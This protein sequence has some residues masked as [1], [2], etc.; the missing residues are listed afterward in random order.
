M[1]DPV[2]SPKKQF[3][4][5][6]TIVT[7]EYLSAT[8]GYG[9]QAA[10]GYGISSAS[11]LYNGH[12]HN[13][14]DTWGCAPRI[15]LGSEVKGF[16]TLPFPQLKTVQMSATQAVGLTSSLFFILQIPDDAISSFINSD[17]ST[18]SCPPALTIL[19]SATGSGGS[20]GNVGFRI[21]W[22]YIALGENVLAPSVVSLNNSAYWPSNLQS[23]SN[24]TPFS[25]SNGT[26]FRFNVASAINSVVYSNNNATQGIENPIQLSFITETNSGI[27]RNTTNSTLL[28]IEVSSSPTI[29]LTSPASEIH[30]FGISVKYYSQ[31]LGITA[32]GIVNGVAN[33]IPNN[34][35]SIV[36]NNGALS[37]Y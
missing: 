24:P 11:P 7:G 17:G 12:L 4:D 14:G 32:N 6:K 18:I 15:D 33:G 1:A 25:I 13:D 2:L 35:G 21:D 36:S 37:D 10:E 26:P 34:N 20:T 8:Y 3:L 30:I 27:T 5:G 29:N 28:G 16:L 9:V 23:A 19:W 22:S 31:Q